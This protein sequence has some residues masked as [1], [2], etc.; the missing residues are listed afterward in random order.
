[1]VKNF[2]QVIPWEHGKKFLPG[3]TMET[4]GTQVNKL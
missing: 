2:Y 1:M 4:V 3:N